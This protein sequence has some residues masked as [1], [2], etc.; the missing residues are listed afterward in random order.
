MRK[1][2]YIFAVFVLCFGSLCGADQMRE[3]QVT[4]AGMKLRFAL[5][6]SASE[7]V[8]APENVPIDALRANGIRT[9]VRAMYDYKNGW[10]PGR[11]GTV[12]VVGT[13]WR[14]GPRQTAAGVSFRDVDGLIRFMAVGSEKE[15]EKVERDGRA[16]IRRTGGK[17][18][19]G[20]PEG[21][22][23]LEWLVPV[24]DELLIMFLVE[25]Q[26]FGPPSKMP[27]KWRVAAQEL[28]QRIFDSFHVD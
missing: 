21:D 12:K 19:K 27:A 20:D 9:F 4:V 24:S 26:H 1:T 6:P 15:Y 5:H 16:F 8:I 2:L 25:L 18:L 7:P 28:Q 13:L 3:H 11:D 23:T 22:V 14:R 17:G 10:K